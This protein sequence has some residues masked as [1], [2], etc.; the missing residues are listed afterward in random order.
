MSFIC[1]WGT[2]Q[3]ATATHTHTHRDQPRSKA[4]HL[5]CTLPQHTATMPEAGLAASTTTTT[6]KT[7][8]GT[9]SGLTNPNTHGNACHCNS[10]QKRWPPPS[11]LAG[12]KFSKNKWKLSMLA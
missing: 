5:N 12:I 2:S 8:L 3:E 4:T 10:H 11:D 6:K 9:N 7:S 1:V